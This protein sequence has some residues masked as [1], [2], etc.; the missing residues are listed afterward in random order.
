[1]L[2][3]LYLNG[4][5]VST[6]Y[7]KAVK[8]FKNATNHPESLYLPGILYL[9]GQGVKKD[10]SLVIQYLKKA[11]M[12]GSKKAKQFLKNKNAFESK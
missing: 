5:G 12:L 9:N 8:W 2:G 4:L 11:A 6:N 1:M 10:H 3:T 7:E